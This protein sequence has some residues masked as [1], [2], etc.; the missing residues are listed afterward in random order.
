MARCGQLRCKGVVPVTLRGWLY[1]F[2]RLLGDREAARKGRLGRRLMRRA[3]GK[4]TGRLLRRLR[5]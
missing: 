1:F 3:A 5:G 4:A 2:A